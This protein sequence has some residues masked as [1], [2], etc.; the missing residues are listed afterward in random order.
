MNKQP[1][2]NQKFDFQKLPMLGFIQ[3]GEMPVLV[4]ES[5]EPIPDSCATGDLV[6][7]AQGQIDVFNRVALQKFCQEIERQKIHAREQ[8]ERGLAGI[9]EECGERIPKARMKAKS[10]ATRC[11]TCQEKCERTGK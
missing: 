6:D 5:Y 11:V 8:S 9:C 3:R 7:R 1:V 4:S 10:W 2:E